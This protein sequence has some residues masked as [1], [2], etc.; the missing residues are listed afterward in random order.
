MQYFIHSSPP[1][2][3]TGGAFSY[4][5]PFALKA[6]IILDYQNVH[7][8]GA[9][10]LGSQYGNHQHY[11]DPI[12]FAETLI[13]ERNSRIREGYAIANV[14]KVLVYRGLPSNIHNP[15]QY[16]RNLTQAAFW[17]RDKRVIVTHRPLKYVF[18]RDELGKVVLGVNGSKIPIGKQEKGIDVLC[19]LALVREVRTADLVILASQDTDLIPA[20]NEATALRLGKVETCSWYLKGNHSSREIRSELVPVWNTRLDANN[21]DKSRDTNDYSKD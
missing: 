20:I 2:S 14:S 8:T 1:S 5:K 6:T 18:E 3:G 15:T 16:A 13:E 17:E 4:D 11:I 9:K 21:F 19:A 7:I 12:R 10:L